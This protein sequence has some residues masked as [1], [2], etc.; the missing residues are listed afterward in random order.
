MYHS[1]RCPNC[2]RKLIEIEG[3]AMAKCPRCKS[4]VD[5][6]TNRGVMARTL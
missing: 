1:V 2:G 3:R 5:I 6:D 4:L